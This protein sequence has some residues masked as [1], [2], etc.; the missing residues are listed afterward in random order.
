MVVG[1]MAR[2]G[3][4]VILLDQ[5][6]TGLSTPL[7][8]QTLTDLL[9]ATREADL[10]AFANADV[11]FEIV[12]DAA[13]AQRSAAFAPFTQVWLTFDQSTL[14]EL[15]GADLVVSSLADVAFEVV[16]GRVRVR[17]RQP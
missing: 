6:G 9:E 3:F 10:G 14:P 13:G 2:S 8:A 11:P 12:V 7:T 17:P 16:D 15:A 5:R 4:D 1:L